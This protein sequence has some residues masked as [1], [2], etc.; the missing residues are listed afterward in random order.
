[1]VWQH[2]LRSRTGTKSLNVPSPSV[3]GR[4]K[5]KWDRKYHNLIT[6]GQG[7][8]F[9]NKLMSGCSLTLVQSGINTMTKCS[10][11]ML[12][13]SG[14]VCD[15]LDG[16]AWALFPASRDK[17]DKVASLKMQECKGS[18][19]VSKILKYFW[20]ENTQ[21]FVSSIFLNTAF[22]E[23]FP[24]SVCLPFKSREAL[25][26]ILTDLKLSTNPPEKAIPK[27][28]VI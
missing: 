6:S 5:R 23:I 24:K 22:Y 2:C 12:F 26:W 8:H 13:S 1:M 25:P 4:T 15:S 18:P 14:Y 17:D 16:R 19:T 7:L 21:F 27:M 20:D 9:P 3:S 10:P 11:A 28:K